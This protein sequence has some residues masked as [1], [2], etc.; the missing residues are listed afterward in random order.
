MRKIKPGSFQDR[1]ESKILFRKPERI[2]QRK[3]WD[4]V[5]LEPSKVEQIVAQA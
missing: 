1:A 5:E 4:D 2:D 3:L